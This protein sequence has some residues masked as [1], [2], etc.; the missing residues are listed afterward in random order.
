MAE[1]TIHA[2][3]DNAEHSAIFNKLFVAW[4]AMAINMSNKE[5]VNGVSVNKGQ[6]IKCA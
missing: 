4:K 2:C 3:S 6:K 1:I 5:K